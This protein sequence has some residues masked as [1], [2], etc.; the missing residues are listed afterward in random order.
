MSDIRSIQIRP[1]HRWTDR[2]N[3]HGWDSSGG[4]VFVCWSEQTTME[5]LDAL[6][7]LLSHEKLAANLYTGNISATGGTAIILGVA[8]AICIII[9]VF[10]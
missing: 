7:R 2:H 6:A 8:L 1:T 10:K 9:Y 5:W 4:A 3:I